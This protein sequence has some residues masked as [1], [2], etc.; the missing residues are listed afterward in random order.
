MRDHATRNRATLESLFEEMG[1]RKSEIKGLLAYT[2]PSKRLVEVLY[3]LKSAGYEMLSDIFGVDW[4]TYPGHPSSQSGGKRF[5]VAYNLYH[6][7]DA[8]RLFVRVELDEG[9][10]LPTATGLWRCANFMEREVFDMFGVEFD[11]HPDLRK[12]LTPEDLDGHPHRKDFPIGETPTLFN[13]GRYLDPASF[14]ASIIGSDS[15]LTGWKGGARKGVR[16]DQELELVD[17]EVTGQ[18]GGLAK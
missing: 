13:D 6:L 7:A 17:Q 4:L 3:A 14:R 11:G 16:S 2:L 15:G 8:H 18:P 10:R 5:T 12:L 1:G 9:E